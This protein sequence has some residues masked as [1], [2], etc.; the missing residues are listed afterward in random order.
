MKTN[1]QNKPLVLILCGGRSLRLWPLCE[2]RSKNFIDVFEFSPLETTIRRF[3]KVT[4]RDNIYLVVQEREKKKF[5][6][7]N[8]I[9]P[10]N[11]FVEPQSKN[12]AAAVL[13]G[14]YRWRNQL[15][16]PIII[17]PVDHLIRKENLFYQA[18]GK[19][20][21]AAERGYICTLGI[22]AKEPNPHFGYIIAGKSLSSGKVFNVRRFVEKPQRAKALQLI[23]SGK[24]FY[25][26]GMFIA[27]VG[28][29]LEEYKR[30]YRPF[31]GFMRSASAGTLAGFYRN[32]KEIP[33]DTAIMEKTK[34]ASVVAGN[35]FWRD[36]GSWHAIYELLSKDSAGNVRRGKVFIRK[37]NRNL[38]FIDNP[39]KKVLITGLDDVFLVDTR[40]HLL[41]TSR[42]CVDELK[43]VLAEFRQQ[44]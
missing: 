34:K 21:Q 25:N 16:R 3:L 23:R 12:T 11:I 33:F 37:A 31:K 44:R 20:L 10:E 35:F 15:Q 24:C 14:L 5:C 40:D 39:Q 27:K 32:I 29:L 18:L 28:T 8:Q 13:L 17:S 43:T 4:S 9:K 42:A 7:L 26:S 38:V 2:Y 6:S 36:F 19:A 30:Y 41:L 22:R 1:E